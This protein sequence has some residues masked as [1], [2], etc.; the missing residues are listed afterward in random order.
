[1]KI[2]GGQIIQVLKIVEK[3]RLICQDMFIPVLNPKS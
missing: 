3:I 2:V 1:V